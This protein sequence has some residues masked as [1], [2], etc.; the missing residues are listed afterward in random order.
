MPKSISQNQ[1]LTLPVGWREDLT[2]ENFYAGQNQQAVAL[3]QQMSTCVGEKTCY[4]WGA[5]GVGRSH[6]LQASCHL[7][8]EQGLVA[9]YVPLH[10]FKSVSANVLEGLENLALVCID[11][12]DA[13][14]GLTHW[15]EALFHLY[16]R[17]LSQPVRLIFAAKAMPQAINLQ[18]A[19]LVSRLAASLI[20]HLVDLSDKEKNYALQLRAKQRGLELSDEVGQFLLKRCP[21]DNQQLFAILDQLD[22]ASLAEQRRISIP[23]VK[24]V[25]GI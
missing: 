7:A 25:L 8:G 14:A 16:N 10:N 17:S 12:I 21:R 6:L 24:S 4:L 2:F 18:L 22:Q 1:Q 3:L 19:D 13:I 23:F 5:A 9:S 11:D 15:E 20:F